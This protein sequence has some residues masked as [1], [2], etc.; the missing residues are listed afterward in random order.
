MMKLVSI[1]IQVLVGVV[2][3]FYFIKIIKK[4]VFGNLWGAIVVGI[5]GSVLGGFFLNKIID[6][7]VN[8]GLT[9]NFVACFIGSFFFIWLVSKITH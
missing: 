8:N 6:V 9:V 7:M 5:I 4:P 1:S 3:A 2:A